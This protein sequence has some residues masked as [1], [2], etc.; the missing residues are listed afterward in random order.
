[1]ASPES[2]ARDALG[3]LL[4]DLF[5][6]VGGQ[7]DKQP[8]KQPV[9]S[10]GAGERKPTPRTP[11]GPSLKPAASHKRLRSASAHDAEPIKD[12]RSPDHPLPL[13]LLVPR[14]RDD[15]NGRHEGRRGDREAAADTHDQRR[16]K[17][18][19]LSAQAAWLLSPALTADEKVPA[20]PPASRADRRLTLAPV[21]RSASHCR[22]CSTSACRTSPKPT[23]RC[24]RRSTSLC[25]PN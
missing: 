13:L 6:D 18:P 12:S 11:N 9:D 4:A 7:P 2:P 22:C 15:T 3:A 14:D 25:A 21:R 10:D 17:M 1:M 20:T 16:C 19:R 23:G 5:S 24:S 8:D